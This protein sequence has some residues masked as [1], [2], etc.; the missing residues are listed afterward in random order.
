MMLNY[1]KDNCDIQLCETACDFYI[2]KSCNN[3]F[4]LSSMNDEFST[5]NYSKA[6]KWINS[7]AKDFEALILCGYDDN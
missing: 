1:K 5:S 2:V 7:N 6:K 4:E 3:H